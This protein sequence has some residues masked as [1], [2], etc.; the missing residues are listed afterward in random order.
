VENHIEEFGTIDI[1]IN[2]AAEQHLCD[3]LDQID[4]DQVERTF[5]TNG[6]TVVV[7]SK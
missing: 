1:L 3:T 4:L 2:N 7:V 5:K 6:N